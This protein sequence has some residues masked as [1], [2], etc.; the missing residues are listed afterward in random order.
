M[1]RPQPRRP[2]RFS[3]ASRSGFVLI[4]VL[5]VIAMLTLAGFRFSEAMFVQREAVHL[6]GRSVETRLAAESGVEFA[7]AFLSLPTQTRE[8]LGGAFHNPDHFQGVIVSG[9]GPGE[10]PLRFSLVAPSLADEEPPKLRFGLGCE[11]ARLNLQSL[12]EWDQLHPGAARGALLNLPGMTEELADAIL[13]WIDPDDAPREFGAE[14]EF[15]EK[16]LPP[17]APTNAPPRSLEELLWVRGVT[18]TQLFGDDANQNGCVDPHEFEAARDTTRDA[19]RNTGPLGWSAYLTLHSAEGNRAP[20]GQPKID[21][22]QDDLH[23]LYD[24]LTRAFEDESWATFIVAYRQFGPYRGLAPSATGRPLPPDFSVPPR[25]RIDSVLDLIAVRVQI[26]HP[27]LPLFVLP[28]PFENNR[29]AMHDYL[30]KLWERVTASSQ[31]VVG[32]VNVNEAPREVLLGIPGMSAGLVEDLIAKR[33]R[34]PGVVDRSHRHVIWLLTEGL[35]D[36][37][38]MKSLLPFIT[39]EGDVFRAQTVG[40]RDDGSVFR[41]ELVLDATETTVRL[42]SWR[43]LGRLG[44]GYDLAVLGLMPPRELPLPTVNNTP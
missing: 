28:C 13:D 6:Q 14:R 10:T 3:P 9:D 44:R 19:R 25:F 43:E 24:Q 20:D 31:R 17:Y 29:A 1:N 12:L 38:Q 8:E 18:R 41:A 40:Y 16:L 32:R 22:N 27:N 39:T 36:L 4:V 33:G 11:S 23:E 26:A 34:E 30:P 42:V 7:K 21:L 15:Y 37:E 5:I 35:V 2:A